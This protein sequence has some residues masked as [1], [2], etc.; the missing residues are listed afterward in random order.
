M[1]SAAQV[2]KG[3]EILNSNLKYY[4]QTPIAS[5]WFLRIHD[6]LEKLFS[7]KVDGIKRTLAE[8]I[9]MDE[10]EKQQDD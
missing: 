10:M 1:Y 4:P 5:V 8:Q 2:P 9:L 6:W 3:M 7:L